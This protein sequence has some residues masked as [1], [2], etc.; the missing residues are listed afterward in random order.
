MSMQSVS[1]AHYQLRYAPLERETPAL[2]FPC[3]VHGRVELDGLSDRARV[4]YLFARA[5]VGL[6]FARPAV[7][8][9]TLTCLA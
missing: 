1:D 3:D 8:E 6:L 4:D 9:G 5:V 2:E 7:V